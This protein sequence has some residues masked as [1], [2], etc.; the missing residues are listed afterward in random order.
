MEKQRQDGIFNGMDKTI[1]K[2]GLELIIKFEDLILKPYKSPNGMI[3]IGYG[4][5]YY[6]NGV[7]VTKQDQQITPQRAEELLRF[8]L[9]TYEKYINTA[10]R[11]DINQNQFDA[12]VSICYDIGITNFRNSKLMIRL[13][14]DPNDPQIITEFNKWNKLNNYIAARQTYR[15]QLEYKLYNS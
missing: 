1:S 3:A 2:T 15:R 9:S 7:K 4:N 13:N 6:E 8:T 5:T 12:L 11:N 14:K 10:C